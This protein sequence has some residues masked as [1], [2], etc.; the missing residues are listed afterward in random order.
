M[1]LRTFHSVLEKLC[2]CATYHRDYFL[3]SI[4]AVER[5]MKI[6]KNV[7]KLKSVNPFKPAFNSVT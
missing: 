7:I 1:S 3:S 4:Q 6:V 5:A 2:F